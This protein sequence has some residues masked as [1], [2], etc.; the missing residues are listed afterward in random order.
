MKKFKLFFGIVKLVKDCEPC[1]TQCYDS[2]VELFKP[3]SNE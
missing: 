2:I 3:K 1:L